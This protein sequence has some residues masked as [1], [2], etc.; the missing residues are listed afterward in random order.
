MSIMYI[1]DGIAGCSSKQQASEAS[2][3]IQSDLIRNAGWKA[4][5]Q[6]S[7]WEPVQIGEWLGIIINTIWAIFIVPEKKIRKAKG[8]LNGKYYDNLTKLYFSARLLV[9]ADFQNRDTRRVPN[10]VEPGFGILK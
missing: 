10:K 6:K 4:N 9:R 2:H 7:Y 8:V 3:S 5:N 1:D